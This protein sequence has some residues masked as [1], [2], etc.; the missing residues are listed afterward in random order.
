MPQANLLGFNNSSGQLDVTAVDDATAVP[1]TATFRGGMAYTPAGSLYVT[2]GEP[3]GGAA[4]QT[5][6]LVGGFRVRTDGALLIDGSA[7]TSAVNG[8]PVISGRLSVVSLG[9]PTTYTHG[10]GINGN[11]VCVNI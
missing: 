4:P 2:V 1:A 6:V 10:V 3:A 9:T 5:V 8:M 7:A 11:Q